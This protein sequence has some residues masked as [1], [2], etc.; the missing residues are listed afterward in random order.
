MTMWCSDAILKYLG[1]FDFSELDP[2][3]S[4]PNMATPPPDSRIVWQFMRFDPRTISVPTTHAYVNNR[5]SHVN[6]VSNL[7]DGGGRL[8]VCYTDQESEV[9]ITNQSQDNG[10]C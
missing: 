8:A 5:I 10:N 7:V 3:L 1:P 6:I 9:L 4:G 2:S